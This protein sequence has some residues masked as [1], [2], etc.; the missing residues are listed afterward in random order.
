MTYAKA[1][2][3]RNSER[4]RAQQRAHYKNNLEK[5]KARAQEQAYR[6]IHKASQKAYRARNP[7]KNSRPSN[8][9]TCHP[10][11]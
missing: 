4:L 9:S 7:G 5:I 11:A 1:Y 10:P 8:S 2:R 3:E 6:D